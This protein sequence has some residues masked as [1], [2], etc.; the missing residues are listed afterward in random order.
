[1]QDAFTGQLTRIRGTALP[2]AP[3][4]ASLQDDHERRLEALARLGAAAAQCGLRTDTD[5]DLVLLAEDEVSLLEGAAPG[6]SRRT[7]STR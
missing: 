5:R 7:C 4:R 1:M 2:D 3:A 6:P